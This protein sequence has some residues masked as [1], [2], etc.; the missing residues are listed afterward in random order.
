MTPAWEA[1]AGSE[2]KIRV[3][4]KGV[5]PMTLLLLVQMLYHWAAGD[6]WEPRPPN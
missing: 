3:L 5:D 4:S 2:E 1:T 6:L